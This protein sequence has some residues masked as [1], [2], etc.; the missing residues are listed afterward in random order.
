MN[1]S[2]G[3]AADCKWKKYIRP[4]VMSS[5]SPDIF[6]PRPD[7]NMPELLQQGLD[8][9]DPMP[10]FQV[11]FSRKRSLTPKAERAAS[12]VSPIT[13]LIVLGHNHWFPDFHAPP[14]LFSE[15][16]VLGKEL[17]TH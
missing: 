2:K 1:K 14:H 6:K 10:R 7:H 9:L 16:P 13:T 12:W 5:P 3:R 8:K 11:T 4:W 17:G 15:F